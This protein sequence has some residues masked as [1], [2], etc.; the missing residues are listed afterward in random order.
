MSQ[1]GQTGVMAIAIALAAIV[2]AALAAWFLKRRTRDRSSDLHLSRALL[3]AGEEITRQASTL[4]SRKQEL[5]GSG[6]GDFGRARWSR[7][8][9]LFC[10]VQIVPI[11]AREGLSRQWKM[12][13]QTVTEEIDVAASEPL[14]DAVTTADRNDR[15]VAHSTMSRSDYSQLCASLL[16]KAGWDTQ[17]T[18]DS[19]LLARRDS[20]VLFLGCT[21]RDDAVD[22]AGVLDVATARAA[23]GVGFAAIVSNAPFTSAACR[24]AVLNAVFLLHHDDLATFSIAGFTEGLAPALRGARD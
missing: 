24:A 9:A 7:E 8:I 3:L 12:I 20:D 23:Q 19:L 5:I 13:E 14:A 22:A 10:R 17:T 15:Q 1:T 2:L 21:P 16:S 11:L 4:R 18:A 6:R